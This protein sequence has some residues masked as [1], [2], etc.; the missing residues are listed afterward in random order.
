[1]KISRTNKLSN[2]S[3]LNN[4]HDEI[5]AS[6]LD[7]RLEDLSNVKC[8]ILAG[9]FGTRISEESAI[10]PKPMVV[11]GTMPI[12]W[13]IMKYYHS[14]GVTDFIICCGYKGDDITNFF[15]NYS[16][17]KSDLTIDLKNN[18]VTIHKNNVEPWKVTLID[19]GEE[20]MTGGR[21]KR[22]KNYVGNESFLLAY[23]DGLSDVNLIELYKLH[24][25]EKA[26]V[27]VTAVQPPGRFGV[28]SLYESSSKITRFREKTTET[29]GG[30]W[31][32]GGFFVVEPEAL[33][34]IRDD[35]TV[36]E[37]EPLERLARDGKLSAFKHKGF[38]HPM[39]SLHDKISLESIWQSGIAPWKIWK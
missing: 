28:F 11:I 10:R 7:K 14:Y 4:K 30:A 3:H 20:T 39:D 38:W 13:H 9:G 33:E 15:L 22:I 29:V 35:S 8:V 27:T 21:I 2:S 24:Q 19:T 25:Q 34:Y 31:I 37:R 26:L 5:T 1:M 12:L 36:W 32:N 16:H 17:L 6:S 23:G 18:N